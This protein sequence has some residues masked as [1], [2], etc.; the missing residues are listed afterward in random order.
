MGAR[1]IQRTAAENDARAHIAPSVSEFSRISNEQGLKSALQW[2]DAKFGDGKARV[3]GAE[4]RDE[5]GR[6]V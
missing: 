2:R 3:L 1:T 5:H 4:M 6:L